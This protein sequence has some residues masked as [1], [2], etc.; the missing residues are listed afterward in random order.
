MADYADWN[1]EMQ[2]KCIYL[3]KELFHYEPNYIP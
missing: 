3:R 2:K 1:L